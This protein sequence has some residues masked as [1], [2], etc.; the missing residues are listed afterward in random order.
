MDTGLFH[1]SVMVM[2]LDIQRNN[3]AIASA[4]GRITE[5]ERQVVA[6]I[7]RAIIDQ[8]EAMLSTIQRC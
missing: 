3:E 2:L 4:V 7:L 6:P 5:D 8:Q 1:A